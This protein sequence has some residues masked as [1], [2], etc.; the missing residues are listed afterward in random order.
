V[1]GHCNR[2]FGQVEDLAALHSGYWPPRQPGP[3]PPAPARLMA[4]LP[5][6]PGH[7]RQRRALMPVLPAGLAAAFLPQR[8]RP[9]WRLIQP[10]AR[11]RL[12][13]IPRRLPQP[14][15]QLSDPLPRLRQFPERPSQRSLRLR[16]LRAQ[17]GHHSR[18]H[19]IAGTGIITR[20]SPDATTTSDRIPR[21]PASSICPPAE[22]GQSAVP[23]PAVITGA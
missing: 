7:L 6:R 20:H 17:R 9:R 19:L 23:C 4:D 11:R 14:R 22:P 10:L 13:G 8:P 12:R 2:H 5:V 21:D 18:Q 16:Q 15:L 1:L 3:A